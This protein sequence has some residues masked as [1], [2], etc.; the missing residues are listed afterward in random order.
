MAGSS[1]KTSIAA[2]G[3]SGGERRLERAAARSDPARAVLTS[4][5]S[6]LHQREMCARDDA[7]RLG[8][9]IQMEA[10]DVGA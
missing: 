1:S 7:A 10:D 9:Q 3:A 8:R 4:S 2:A 5:A 6:R